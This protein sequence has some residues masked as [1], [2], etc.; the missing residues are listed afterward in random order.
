MKAKGLEFIEK[1]INTKSEKTKNQNPLMDNNATSK[2]QGRHSRVLQHR[3]TNNE[4][5]WSLMLQSDEIQI[6]NKQL[7]LTAAKLE[8]NCTDL[9][10]HLKTLPTTFMQLICWNMHTLLS[11]GWI[12][13]GHKTNTH[14][15]KINRMYFKDNFQNKLSNWSFTCKKN[16]ENSATAA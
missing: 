6:E 4:P 9:C 11:P 3:S 7:I 12:Y 10:N 15:A 16:L 8:E 14:C 2:V 13:W 1:Q 5:N